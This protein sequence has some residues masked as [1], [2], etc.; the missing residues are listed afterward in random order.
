VVEEILRQ[1]NALGVGYDIRTTAPLRCGGGSDTGSDFG[2]VAVEIKH[3]STVNA[4]ELR[5]SATSSGSTRH[6][7]LGVNTTA[8][9][10]NTM[11]SCWDCRSTG[12]KSRAPNPHTPRARLFG[13]GEIR[14]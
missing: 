1:L 9:S 8:R 5:G 4:R 2:R 11:R 7:W 6:A 10:G 12:C 13:C 14:N 3:T